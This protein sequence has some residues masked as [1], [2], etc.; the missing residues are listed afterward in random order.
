MNEQVGRWIRGISRFL[1][2]AIVPKW[3]GS[4]G[5]GWMNCM[6]LRYSQDHHHMYR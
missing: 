6:V 4:E 1:G 5:D 3:T 2:Y